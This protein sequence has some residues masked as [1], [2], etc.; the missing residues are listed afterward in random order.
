MLKNHKK[1]MI[2]CFL[3]TII[4]WAIMGNMLIFDRK[5]ATI[6]LECYDKNKVIFSR[7]IISLNIIFILLIWVFIVLENKNKIQFTIVLLINAILINSFMYLAILKEKPE[8]YIY[9]MVGEFTITIIIEIIKIT[10]YRMKKNSVIIKAEPTGKAVL[11]KI[12]E[13]EKEKED[14]NI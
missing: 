13:D 10:K 7:A 8:Y 9:Y 11:C 5:S 1:A 4:T 14:D 3:S 2:I 12:R 6:F